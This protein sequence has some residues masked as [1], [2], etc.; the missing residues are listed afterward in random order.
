M[1]DELTLQNPS[2]PNFLDPNVTQTKYH[3]LEIKE[4]P[5]R[6]EL[7]EDTDDIYQRIPGGNTYILNLGEFLV[8]NNENHLLYNKLRQANPNDLLEIYISSNGGYIFEITEFYNIIK[9][10]FS[11]IVTFLNYGYSAGSIAFLMGVERIVYEHSDFMIHSYSGGGY[12][13]RDDMIKHIHHNDKKITKLFEKI[14]SPYMTKKELK[15]INRGDDYWMDADEMLKRGI[16]TGI[17][18]DTGEYKTREEYLGLKTEKETKKVDYFE[19]LDMT[20]KP[21]QKPKK[22]KTKKTKKDK[23]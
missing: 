4:E 19:G 17:I 9:P 7:I 13:K 14:Y 15:K 6:F 18:L 10:K 20:Y 11:N 22:E 5:D 8:E 12:G 23:K 21:K 16:A 1:K 3:T 2:I